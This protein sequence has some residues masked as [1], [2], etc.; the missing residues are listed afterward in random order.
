MDVMHTFVNPEA[1]YYF[2][3]WVFLK[4]LG[5]SYLIAF[6]SL[7]LQVKGLYGSRGIIPLTEI[8]KGI[9]KSR[10]YQHLYYT[11]SVFWLSTDDKMLQGVA[12]VGVLGSL[13]VLG[14]VGV[15]WILLLLCFL[16]LSYVSACIYFLSFQWDVLLIEVGFAGFIFSL[17]T[18]PLPIVIFL[19]WVILFRFIFSSGI[20]KFLMGSED[21]RD[22]T[23]MKYHYETQP[24]PNRIAYYF[25]QQPLWFAKL[26][27]AG[28]FLVEVLIPFL[29]FSTDEI[30]VWVVF[31]SFVSLQLLIMFTGNF[32]FFNIITLAL[33][34][35]LVSDQSVP[36]VASYFPS[37]KISSS[38]GT[39]IFVSMSSML[40]I[41]LNF[42]QLVQLFRAMPFVERVLRSISP[43][44]FI[45]PYGLFSHMTQKRYEIEIEGSQD[46]ETWESYIFKWK[47]GNLNSVPGMIAPHQPRLDWQMWF[48]ALGHYKQNP[49]FTRFIYRLL[50]N[51]PDVLKLMKHYPTQ[52][53]KYIRAN[54]YEYKFT[55]LKE[56]KETGNWWKRSYV[57]PYI[58]PVSKD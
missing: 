47:P 52:P 11:P 32:A 34:F 1:T 28:V 13:L 40:L 26:S 41:V 56:K 23:A 4:L 53:P 35:T 24:L 5:F 14:G 12:L 30:R 31:G 39:S 20:A 18:P 3:Q 50:E 6:G 42:F 51:A 8:F 54:L 2:A 7:F 45:N 46:G 16:Y 29:I 33:C 9:K 48:A 38:V 58:P 17:Q 21:W 44:F 22:L 49:W 36:W 27:T 15:P 37:E 10:Y 55:T 57:K 19:M 25:H 43:F